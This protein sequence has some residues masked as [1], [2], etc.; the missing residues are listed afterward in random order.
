[1]A[2]DIE[3]SKITSQTVGRAT[4]NVTKV[5]SERVNMMMTKIA[6]REAGVWTEEALAAPRPKPIEIPRGPEVRPNTV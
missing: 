1:M 5:S 6:A 2:V 3:S 4:H